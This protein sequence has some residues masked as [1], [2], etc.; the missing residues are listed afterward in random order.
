MVPGGVKAS[1][2]AV[3]SSLDWPGAENEQSS[4]PSSCMS[5][6][7]DPPWCAHCQ[8]CDVIVWHLPPWKCGWSQAVHHLYTS[9]QEVCQEG[10]GPTMLEQFDNS[11]SSLTSHWTIWWLSKVKGY[12]FQSL[13]TEKS[14]VL[15][16]DISILWPGGGCPWAAKTIHGLSTRSV[17]Y[18]NIPQN[19]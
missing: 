14:W 10:L 1:E 12:V 5:N 13:K 8:S 15:T 9:S 16:Y 2:C 17:K 4:S 7:S 6:I 11:A 3:W 19:G 18:K